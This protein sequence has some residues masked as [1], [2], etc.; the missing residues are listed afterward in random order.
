MGST[1]ER[2][3]WWIW[4]SWFLLGFGIHHQPGKFFFEARKVLQMIFFR[5]WLCTFSS[6]LQKRTQKAQMCNMCHFAQLD[7]PVYYTSR[8]HVFNSAGREILKVKVSKK[9]TTSVD[10]ERL[11]IPKNGGGDN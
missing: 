3:R 4:F 11:H 7:N 10:A 1:E 8:L 6:S 2:F 9:L 5:W